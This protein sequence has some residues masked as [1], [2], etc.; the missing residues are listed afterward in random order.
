MKAQN[1]F[2]RLV[3]EDFDHADLADLKLLTLAVWYQAF[4]PDV[5]VLELKEAR[6]ACYLLDRLMRFNCVSPGQ[7]AKLIAAIDILSKKYD[8][9][10]EGVLSTDRKMDKHAR[11]W[12]LDSGLK[13]MFKKMLPY[14]TRHYKPE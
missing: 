11:S 1:A 9:Q 7:Q 6:P 10:R 12:G 14:Q 8:V 13:L 5:E 4:V 3:S 2:E